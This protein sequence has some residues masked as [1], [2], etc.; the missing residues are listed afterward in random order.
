MRALIFQ[1]GMSLTAWVEALPPGYCIASNCAYTLSEHLIT[2]RNGPQ[3]YCKLI[4][5]FITATNH[6]DTVTRD[7]FYQWCITIARDK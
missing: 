3:W 7:N 4:T 1:Y 6:H 5:F 2:P